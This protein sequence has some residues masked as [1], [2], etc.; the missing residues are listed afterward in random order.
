M[1]KEREYYFFF[2]QVFQNYSFKAFYGNFSMLK[3]NGFSRLRL[4]Q[5][6][7]ILCYSMIKASDKGLK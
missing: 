6:H 5:G 4:Y 1:V 3:V 2:L 7:I